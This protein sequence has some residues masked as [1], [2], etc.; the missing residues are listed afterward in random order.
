M[1]P[2]FRAF[3]ILFGLIIGY[4]FGDWYQMKISIDPHGP[5]SKDIVGSVF[6]FGE[7]YYTFSPEVCICPLR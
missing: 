5:N 3:I 7:K 6:Q 2:V 1:H 4:V